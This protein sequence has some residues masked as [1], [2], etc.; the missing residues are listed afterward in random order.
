MRAFITVIGQDQVGIL[1]RVAT[2][3]ANHQANI[4]DV[5]QTVSHDYFNMIMLVELDQLDIDFGE[6]KQELET[7]DPYLRIRVD[8]ES[9]FNAMHEI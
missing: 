8:H 4:I 6:F 2:I 9:I 7:L 1:A 3:C 5:E